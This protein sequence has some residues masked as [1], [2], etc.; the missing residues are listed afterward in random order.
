V[1]EGAGVEPKKASRF[2]GRLWHHLDFLK[3]WTGDTITQFTG[4]V[5]GL[6]LPTVA[7]VT[8]GATGFELGVLN[9]LSLVAFP[10][11][12]LFVGVW[13]DRMRRRPVMIV[14]DLVELAMLAT[15]P[16]AFVFGVLGIYQLYVIAAVTGVCTLFFDVAYQS[17]LPSLVSKD[18]VL[19]GNQKLQI[20]ASAAQVT[21]PAIAS[22]MMGLLG[23]AMS[24]IADVVGTLVGAA[25]L[26]FIRKP[27]PDPQAN[28]TGQQ[29]RFFAE[30]K[31]GIR[32]V[33]GNKLLWT[34]AGCTATANLGFSIFYVALILFAYRILLFTPALI[35]IPF[36]IG[37][38]GF[39]VGVLMS[40]R[41]TGTLGLGRSIALASVLPIFELIALLATGGFKIELLGLALFVGN[42]GIPIYNI[43][44]VSLRQIITP[45]RLQGRMN[46]TMRTLVW[47]TQPV[48][49]LIGGALVT[50]V[51][52]TPAMVVGAVISG[53]AFLWIVLGPIFKLKKQPEPVGD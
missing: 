36:S 29:R 32:V 53:S 21:G 13:M 26:L 12:G 50:L 10:V 15:I 35:G 46:A 8:L 24:V 38:L 5:S 37:A 43:N 41:V 39:L 49:S 14:A 6:A 4:Q 31:E 42:L 51:G 20:S 25:M 2:K 9:A 17:Y 16:V 3:F 52:I 34:Q 44:Q 7:V 1:G 45:N 47:G 28:A 23:A 33:T 40:P 19:E 11:L 27:E 22:G 30:M 48:G 18:D